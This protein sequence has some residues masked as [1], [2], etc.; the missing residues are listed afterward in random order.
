MIMAIVQSFFS[1]QTSKPSAKRSLKR[2][3]TFSTPEMSRIHDSS[4]STFAGLLYNQ[5]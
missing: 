2:L 4:I 3:Q 1:Q 5:H